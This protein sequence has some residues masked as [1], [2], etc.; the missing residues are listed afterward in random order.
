MPSSWAAGLLQ[1]NPPSPYPF[2]FTATSKYG[3][4]ESAQVQAHDLHAPDR[5]HLAVLTQAHPC[6][7]DPGQAASIPPPFASLDEKGM[8]VSAS[9][10]CIV[11]QW[12]VRSASRRIS[13][14]SRLHLFPPSGRVPDDR[15]A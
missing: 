13:F 10:A 11:T 14:F 4:D 5:H 2:T 1:T 12:V 6:V 8:T 7:D 3:I 9:E 15:S